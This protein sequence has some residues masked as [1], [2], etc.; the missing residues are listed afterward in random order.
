MRGTILLRERMTI[1]VH[2]G[3]PGH[4][5]WRRRLWGRF[6]AWRAAWQ[7]RRVWNRTGC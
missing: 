3:D 5:S 7:F 6:Q 4:I 1:T 2:T